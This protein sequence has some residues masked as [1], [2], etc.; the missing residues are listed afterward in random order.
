MSTK[1]V[2]ELGMY[3]FIRFLVDGS[4]QVVKP[5]LLLD[6]PV[7]GNSTLRA[8]TTMTKQ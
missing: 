6:G 8:A 4:V 1:S 7:D 2:S 3:L 5:W